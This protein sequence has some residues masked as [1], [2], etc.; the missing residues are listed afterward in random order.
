[1]FLRG[2]TFS[3]VTALT[4]ALAI[5]CSGSGSSAGSDG[6][7]AGGS[8][9]QS[10]GG[11]A[12]TSGT[13]GAGGSGAQSSGGTG[14]S[15][16]SKVD[17][18]FDDPN[19]AAPP[20]FGSSAD[21]TIS[22]RLP[23]ARAAVGI[24]TYE[25]EFLV[26]LATTRSTIDLLAFTAPGPTATGCDPSFLGQ[27]CSFAAFDFFGP[28]GSVQLV[29]A[30]HSFV[31]GSVRQAGIL[32]T[33]FLATV[34]VSL[35][36]SH[37]EIYRALS[38]ALCTDAELAATG[39]TALSSAGFFASDPTK[40]AALSEVR[41]GAPAGL[42]VPNVPTV[43]LRIAGVDTV[44][45]LDTGF[46]DSLVP[47]SINV[48]EALF[49]AISQLA[50]GALERAAD[51]D[52]AL[53]TCAGVA[54]LVEAYGL[55]AGHAVQFIDGGGSAARSYPTATLFVKHTPPAAQV[56]GGIG[57]WTV[58]AAQL[59]ASFF[60]DGKLWVFDPFTSRVWL[61]HD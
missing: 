50:P 39:L 20:C 23:Y 33:D 59:G 61:A 45:Q 26:D 48:N 37:H 29:T 24:P 14:G 9:A 11:S 12:G 8:G 6:G 56:C 1:M 47:Y 27:S 49:A 18:P 16:G 52:I 41:A 46:D 22:S 30:D 51:K 54:E 38:G 36:Y 42:A 15:G 31:V 17:S 55:A 5:A 40:L 60:I 25:G 21:L 13:S 43:P 4:A 28:W 44:V 2:P 34:A 35:D 57:T 32:G 58:P 10:S 3:L 19:W 7:G 53:T